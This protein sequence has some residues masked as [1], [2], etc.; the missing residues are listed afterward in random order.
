MFNTSKLNKE[1]TNFLIF[2]HPHR[3]LFGEILKYL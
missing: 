1:K 2:D 3:K